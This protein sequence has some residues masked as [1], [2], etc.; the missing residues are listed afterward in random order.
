MRERTAEIALQRERLRREKERV[1]A[2]NAEL[3]DA[4]E[5]ALRAAQTKSEFLATMSHEIRTPMN[6]VIGMTGLLLDTPLSD[7]QRDYLDV[8]RSSGDALLALINDILDFSKIDAGRVELEEHPFEPHVVIEDAIDLVA[9]RATEAGVHV[10]YLL[11]PEVPR[12]VTADMARVRQVVVN[13]LS[14]AVKFTHEGTI[15]VTVGYAPGAEGA[16]RLCVAVRDSGI[17]IPDDK[18]GAL[19]DAFTQAD[20]STTRKYGGTGLGLAISKRLVEAMGGRLRVESTP[21]PAPGHGSTFSFEIDVAPAD[22]Q[23]PP[24]SLRDRHVLAVDDIELNRRM[25]GLQL[26]RLGAIVTLAASGREAVAAAQARRFDAVVL[27]MHMPSEDGVTTAERLRRALGDAT[28]PLVMLSSLGERPAEAEGLFA[29]WLTKPTKQDALGRTLGRVLAGAPETAPSATPDAERKALRILLAED[30]L[31]N[32][33]VAVRTLERLGYR[34]D[35]VSD[36]AEAV[37]AVA[38]AI[39]VGVPYDVVLMDV[40]MPV[41]DGLD[42]TRQIR[43]EAAVQPRIVGMSANAMAEDDEAARRAGMDA[44]LTKP[45]RRE[46]LQAAL[47]AAAPEDASGSVPAGDGH[48]AA[49]PVAAEPARR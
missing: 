21:A 41:L 34:T 45:V 47:D 46:A 14:N 27:D 22:G 13:L 20:T 1:E 6:G 31:V 4:R 2:A 29:A 16:G 38:A 36:G 8:I 19:F 17:G 30:N 9:Q 12:A 25:I 11:A 49:P 33:K 42:A 44:Y 28:P 24:A 39:E 10:A 18:L 3:A 35:V 26:E 43:A 15:E 23:A 37:Q 7:E 5:E 40:Q 48:G 32:Q